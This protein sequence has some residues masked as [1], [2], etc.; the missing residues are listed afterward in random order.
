MYPSKAN[1]YLA[2]LSDEAYVDDKINFW[3]DVYGFDYTC[4]M[5][6]PLVFF[7]LPFTLIPPS[8]LPLALFPLSSPSSLSPLPVSLSPHLSLFSFSQRF[9]PGNRM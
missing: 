6:E 8:I 1:M 3:K 7:P 2:P 4:I 9:V 5:Y